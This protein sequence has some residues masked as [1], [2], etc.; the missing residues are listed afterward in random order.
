MELGQYVSAADK[1]EYGIQFAMKSESKIYQ[2][3]G[4]LRLHELY[5]KL[6]KPDS[7]LILFKKHQEIEEELYNIEK[8]KQIDELRT[9]YETEKKEQQI[10]IQNA[11]IVDKER[12]IEANRKLIILLVLL[13]VSITILSFLVYQRFKTKKETEL[14]KKII[15]EQ[16]KGLDAVI[17]A[18]EEER[19][20]ISKELHDGIGQQL[21]GLKMNFQRLGKQLEDN[22]GSFKKEVDQLT[23]IISESADEVRSI[24]HQMMPRALV[25]LGLVEAITDLTKK[26]LISNEI[27]CDFEHYNLKERYNERIEV[28]VYRIVQELINNIIKHSE[29][30]QVNIQLFQN[31]QK[32]ILI[33]EDNGKG[34]NQD[35][36]S[37]GHGLLNI[38]SRLNTLKGEVNFEPSPKSGSIATIRIQL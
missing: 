25:E 6:N 32:L 26:A 2:S 13:I 16:E 34:F 22:S 28:S 15:E 18:Q 35:N 33:V 24:S 31:K 14:Q 9:L 11:R 23:N 3:E 30:T 20:R 27:L 29:A 4:Y 17:H 38:K 21:S 36:H 37:D 10:E 1:I 5:L 7:A 12:K 19:K 8:A